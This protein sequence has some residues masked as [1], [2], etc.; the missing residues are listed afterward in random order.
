MS[1]EITK[2]CWSDNNEDFNCDD[3]GDLLDNN[4]ELT[5]G[6]VVYVGDA[7]PP[8]T[9]DLF[10]AEDAI[11][12]MGERAYEIGGEYGDS[13]PD[14]TPEATE[15]LEAVIAA[16]INKHAKPTFYTVRNVRQH[17]LTEADLK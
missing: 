7:V 1:T 14:V 2:E 15:E 5:V 8:K 12:L 13:Y 6:S 16:W 10:D 17:I 9:S 11:E 4:D 3:L